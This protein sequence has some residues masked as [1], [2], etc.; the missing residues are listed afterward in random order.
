MTDPGVAAS[1][2]RF[3]QFVK[4]GPLIAVS[5][6]IAMDD[7]GLVGP[8]DAAAQAERCFVQLDG[9]L[10]EA[11]SDWDHV[12]KL[13]CFLTA[14]EHYPAYAEAKRRYTPKLAPAG[15]G[16][17]VSGLLVP[18]ACFEVEALAVDPSH[19]AAG[20]ITSYPI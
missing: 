5:G 16:V 20:E 7:Q 18:G 2:P 14:I 11:G 6:Q 12:I 13:T 17:I 8:G 4:A 9:L 19:P 3:S 15:T 10:R 1:R